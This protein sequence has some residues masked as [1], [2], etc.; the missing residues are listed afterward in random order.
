MGSMY[1]K[2]VAETKLK[3]IAAETGFTPG[4]FDKIQSLTNR[5]KEEGF[6]SSDMNDWKQQYSDIVDNSV[7][8]VN[9]INN[10][11]E[12]EKELEKEEK[13][14][15]QQSL[16]V[17]FPDNIND[18]IKTF[19]EFKALSQEDKIYNMLLLNYSVLVTSQHMFYIDN[20]E[21]FQLYQKVIEKIKK[22]I[23]TFPFKIDTFTHD[24]NIHAVLATRQ[25][26]DNIKTITDS[27]EINTINTLE[28]IAHCY[29]SIVAGKRT[30]IELVADLNTAKAL[31]ALG[32]KWKISGWFNLF[33]T[34]DLS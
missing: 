29:S 27:N 3:L 31:Q 21:R 23:L 6:M 12:L 15:D 25:S 5:M 22:E 7:V 13:E 24:D 33:I 4:E 11:Q 16:Q 10:V 26:N 9:N 30:N 19:A 1:S 20:T 34:V 8:M 2:M 17:W 18:Y 28:V 32:F 14:L